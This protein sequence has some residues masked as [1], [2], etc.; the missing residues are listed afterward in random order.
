MYQTSKRKGKRK[1][2]EK[3]YIPLVRQ[4]EIEKKKKKLYLV[5]TKN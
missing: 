4:S 3:I 1:F 2:Q 5:K